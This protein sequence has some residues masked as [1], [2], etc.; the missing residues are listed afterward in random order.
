MT[1]DNER[2]VFAAKM[3]APQGNNWRSSYSVW[4]SVK[5]RLPEHL[6]HVLWCY[7][8]GTGPSSWYSY[9]ITM[10]RGDFFRHN[11]M[12]GEF[13]LDCRPV[14]QELVAWWM[15]MPPAPNSDSA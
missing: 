12:K 7:A 8:D 15:P 5:D 10:H 14:R 4:I 6:Q 9:P 3:E 1:R 13:R 2:A 11:P